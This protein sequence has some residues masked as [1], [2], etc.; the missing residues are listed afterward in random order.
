[1]TVALLFDQFRKNLAVKNADKIST[2][3]DTITGRL[4]FDFW[5]V[6]SKTANSLQVGSYGRRTAIDGVSDLDMVFVLP[7]DLLSRYKNQEGN[8]PSAMLQEVRK[9][10]LRT[11]SNSKITADGQVVA[12]HFHGYRVE[13]LPAF[14]DSDG[15]F[16]Y[17][18]ANKGGSWKKSMPRPEIS[19]ANDMNRRTGGV[20]KNA[21]KM[22]RAWKNH[23]GVGIGGLL[24]DTLVHRF[25]EVTDDY[26]NCGYSSY[27]GLTRD[28][29]A[30]LAGLPE[31]SYWHALGSGQQVKCKA[32]FQNK[33]KK[34][35]RHCDEALNETTLIKQ[36]NKWRPVFGY[37]FPTA[38]S[39]TKSTAITESAG[40]NEEF[41]EN[42]YSVDVSYT[43]SINCEAEAP[44]YKE[45]LRHLLKNGKRVPIG[46]KLKFFVTDESNIPGDAQIFWKV[47]N[48]GEVAV[49]R[50]QLRGEIVPDNGLRERRETS[51]FTGD[52]YVEAYAILDGV[53]VARDR[54]SVP[55]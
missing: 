43:L 4:N 19:A 34:A 14:E 48:E 25:F 3:Y 42:L 28:L 32:K 23:H 20:Y 38:Q 2:R 49:Q 36:A 8:G 10:L 33:A 47:K 40:P 1:M 31:Q 7:D 55:I 22:V 26:D 16:T 52:H 13:V 21:C 5:E 50:K 54:L 39:L 51:D 41:I 12:V 37:V 53:C 6:E 15:N 11:Y 24:V 30:Y 29:F 27:G 35:A 44:S 9:S 45:F 17:G 46:K 18:D